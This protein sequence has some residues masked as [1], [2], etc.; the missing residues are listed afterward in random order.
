MTFRARQSAE[1]PRG[2]YH[3]GQRAR[4]RPIIRCYLGN[5]GMHGCAA[6]NT[7]VSE[8]DLLFSIGTRFND[9]ITGKIE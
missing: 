6:A 9:R 1:R 2:Y 8:C 5:M 4:S 3:H 7:A